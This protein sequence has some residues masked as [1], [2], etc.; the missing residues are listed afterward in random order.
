MSGVRKTNNMSRNNS[1]A[2]YA[3]GYKARPQMS[4]VDRWRHV[5]QRGHQGRV[6]SVSTNSDTM[7]IVTGGVDYTMRVWKF[8]L[9][10][11]AF[12]LMSVVNVPVPAEARAQADEQLSWFGALKQR[13][14]PPQID[15]ASEEA[16]GVTCVHFL[17]D[18][19]TGPIICGTAVGGLHVFDIYAAVSGGDRSRAVHTLEKVHSGKINHI[20]STSCP[21]NLDEENKQEGVESF[22]VLSASMDSSAVVSRLQVKAARNPWRPESKVAKPGLAEIIFFAGGQPDPVKADA[23]SSFDADHCL[24]F[25]GMTK[26]HVL[27]HDSPV[28]ESH[29]L[30]FDIDHSIDWTRAHHLVK[31]ITCT[32]EC[33]WLW[34]SATDPL[35]RLSLFTTTN[36]RLLAEG[37]LVKDD[38][39]DCESHSRFTVVSQRTEVEESRGVSKLR[40]DALLFVIGTQ[41]KTDE[42][43]ASDTATS[44]ECTHTGVWGLRD[45]VVGTKDARGAL[46]FNE[47]MQR[48]F[49]Q[50]GSDSKVA[51]HART[52]VEPLCVYARPSTLIGVDPSEGSA[53][54]VAQ[55]RPTLSVVDLWDLQAVKPGKLVVEPDGPASLLVTPG[56][57]NTFLQLSQTSNVA[58]M[59]VAKDEAGYPVLVIGRDDGAA[60]EWDLVGDDRGQIIAQLRSLKPLELLVP[61]ILLCTTTIQMF[62]FAFGPAIP[63]EAGVHEK[64]TFVHRV[65]VFDFKCMVTIHK[66]LVFWPEILIIVALI[67]MFIATSF[68]GL[69]ELTDHL[70][71]KCTNWKRFRSEGNRMGPAHLVMKAVSVARSAIYGFMQLAATLL[72]VP[73]MKAAA[74][75]FH[76][77]G[78]PAVVHFAP[79][80]H[81]WEGPH[82]KLTILLAI[83]LPAFMYTLLPNATVGGDSRYVPSTSL[84]DYKF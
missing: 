67:S 7:F 73:I 42:E 70:V 36:K 82:L 44:E 3:H 80:V 81:C 57:T 41:R 19:R 49:C 5:T 9:E 13:I 40:I 35:M 64:A 65:T 46:V 30:D 39:V 24:E 1:G 27:K 78:D 48:E 37:H 8:D 63:W 66:E 53:Q 25:A 76:C 47:D 45:G 34:S 61:V 4:F 62:S 18:K 17:E 56:N 23:E 11:T 83:L 21:A 22:V 77:S 75:A 20:C 26:L 29:C 84:F 71:A 54:F 33:L 59:I 6:N 79:T 72:V 51:S 43:L 16:Q 2:K 10:R 60:V 32:R 69:D 14:A 15:W 50:R 12:D 28:L 31:F 55:W 38:A 58:D 74:A 52:D 68:L